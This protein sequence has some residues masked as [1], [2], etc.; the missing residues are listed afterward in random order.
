MRQLQFCWC[1][2][3]TLTQI[4][5]SSQTKQLY[6]FSTQ[7]MG[8]Q[9]S[10]SFYC[11]HEDQ[12]LK[13]KERCWSELDRLNMIFSDY[14]EQS[15]VSRLSASAGADTWIKVSDPLWEV[16]TT[17]QELFLQSEGA[18]DITIGP[19]S[20][21]WRRAIR[22]QEF[23]KPSDIKS[24]RGLVGSSWMS[25]DQE[26]RSVK[27]AKTHMRIDLGGI[28]KG[29]TIRHLFEELKKLGISQAIV[30]GGEP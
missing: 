11:E 27:L 18:F 23:P 15:E 9:G 7:A 16:L 30:D 19:L 24:A 20:K 29:Y 17:S 13:A 14:E 6:N 21:L 22:R 12:A 28:A 4:S 3:F 10:L 26:T 2:V 1:I 25:F 5:L 8:T